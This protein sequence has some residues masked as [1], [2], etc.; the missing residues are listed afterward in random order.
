M[1]SAQLF[2]IKE[3]NSLMLYEQYKAV[4]SVK[5]EQD[6]KRFNGN[7]LQMVEIE[8]VYDENAKC[9][10]YVFQLQH[11]NRM[12]SNTKLPLSVICV[13]KVMV[14]VSQYVMNRIH[15]WQ[16]IHYVNS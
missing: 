2:Q 16:Q 10:Y 4:V 7:I 14:H 6:C 13:V 8:K 11:E 9:N 12:D 15:S 5:A 3:S 1:S